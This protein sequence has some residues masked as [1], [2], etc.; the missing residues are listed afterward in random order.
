MVKRL[1]IGLWH[2]FGAVVQALAH[3]VVQVLVLAWVV[4]QVWALA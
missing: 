4:V 2:E 3:A 1:W